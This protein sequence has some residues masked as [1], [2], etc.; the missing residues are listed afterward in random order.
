MINDAINF[1]FDYLNRLI[2]AKSWSMMRQICV[3]LYNKKEV[4][5]AGREHEQATK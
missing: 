3:D 2:E 4:R 5:T 1:A